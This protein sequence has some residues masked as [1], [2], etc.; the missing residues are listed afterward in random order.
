MDLATDASSSL[1]E[2]FIPITKPVALYVI[3]QQC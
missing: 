3:R 1:I 2:A